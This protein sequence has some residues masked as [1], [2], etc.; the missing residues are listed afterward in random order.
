M[1]GQADRIGHIWWYE[2]L[3]VKSG[4]GVGVVGQVG[5]QLEWYA[6]PASSLFYFSGRSTGLSTHRF[7]ALRWGL[8]P[9]V[10]VVDRRTIYR[11]LVFTIFQPTDKPPHI[12]FPE[13]LQIS[14]LTFSGFAAERVAKHASQRRVVRGQ[15]E[16]T[17][18]AIF[19]GAGLLRV[20]PHIGELCVSDF[21]CYLAPSSD[22]ER[23]SPKLRMLEKVKQALFFIAITLVTP[24]NHQ[25]K[26]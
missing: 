6:E 17:R 23:I 25:Q 19:H 7:Q 16:E 2:R 11:I 26:V 22:G 8:G 21:P 14:M 9:N 13:L 5:H 10:F 4:R 3:D 20:E 18:E 1:H 12:I 15:Q 24:T